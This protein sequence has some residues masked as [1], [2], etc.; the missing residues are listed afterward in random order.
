MK[1][2][3]YLTPDEVS[4]CVCVCVCVCVVFFFKCTAII[5]AT[6]IN[7][8]AQPSSEQVYQ[9]IIQRSLIMYLSRQGVFM[10]IARCVHV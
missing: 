6:H 1:I 5:R 7:I 3:L 10:P 4:V 9:C 2:P 8:R